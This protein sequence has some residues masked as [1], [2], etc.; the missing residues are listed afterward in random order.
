[1]KNIK[2]RFL[3]DGE[4]YLNDVQDIPRAFSPY[5]VIDNEEEGFLSVDYSYEKGVF[6]CVLKS[7]FEHEVNGSFSI[8]N[9]DTLTYKKKTKSFIKNMLYDYIS[10][11]LAIKL[12]YGSL[13]GVRP[14]KLYNELLDTQ[15]NAFRT[16]IEDYRVSE[17]KAK[18]IKMT[19]EVQ[20][21]IRIKDKRYCNIFVNIPVCPTR[22]NYCSFISSEVERVRPLLSAYTES[23]KKELKKIKSF[24][25]KKDL[26]VRSIYVGGG[27]PT[28][29]GKEYLSNILQEL[30]DI[31]AEF[32]V[33]AGRPDTIDEE[34]LQV[35]KDNNVTRISVNPQSFNQKT[36][37]LIGRR[38][39]VED[40]YHAVEKA[41]KYGF[42]INMDIIALLQG[43]SLTD[44][45]NTVD[46][47]LDTNVEN[48]TVHTLSIKRGA[49]ISKT[50]KQNFGLASEMVS[51]AH[52]KLI[53]DEYRPYYL[54]RQK[55]IADN[56]ENTGFAKEGF[57]CLYNIDIMEET[58]DILGAGAGAMSKYLYDNNRIER[59]FNPKGIKEYIE[60]IEE[61]LCKKTF[62]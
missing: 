20:N 54:Y 23:V 44:F 45:Q 47:A 41:K 5:L 18:L 10:K 48:I 43:E 30:K 46:K 7:S 62:Y 26:T 55:N 32:T 12:P 13:T 40:V 56:L 38:H 57:E 37:D 1:M 19:C 35:M 24:I 22:C 61:I 9:D 33:E 42:V 17:D 3:F 2:A 15:K 8:S 60:R 28:C 4:K 53:K 27:T 6:S 58:I 16:L 36:L 50:K 39:S 29:I 52:K 14:T 25:A 34:I 21:G 31:K 59:F 49:D 11:F 51:Y